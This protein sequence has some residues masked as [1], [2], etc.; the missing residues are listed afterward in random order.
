MVQQQ[1]RQMIAGFKKQRSS[2]KSID[3]F[4]RFSDDIVFD[5]L[6][7]TAAADLTGSLSDLCLI[8]LKR[9]LSSILIAAGFVQTLF[10]GQKIN[11]SSATD[12]VSQFAMGGRSQVLC[13]S[14]ATD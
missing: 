9:R 11:N 13:D 14:F 6:T 1:Q 3:R 4:S 7:T 8:A 12:Y 2:S 10:D 5:P